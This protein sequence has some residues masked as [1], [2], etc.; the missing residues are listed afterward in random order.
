MKNTESKKKIET[1]V[2]GNL[3]EQANKGN[4]QAIREVAELAALHIKD[5]SIRGVRGDDELTDFVVQA[6]KKISETSTPNDAFGWSRRGAQPKN[7]A[8]LEWNLAQY[9]KEVLPQVDGNVELAIKIVG[10]AANMAGGKGGTME[11]IYY[12][13]KDIDL[14][15]DIF[16]SPPDTLQRIKR[17]ERRLSGIL[18]RDQ[19]K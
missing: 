13:W 10:E 1:F 4:H 8:E 3:M 6:L 15:E 11:T 12:R 9:I 2:D 16:P 18:K 19:Q 14:P 7:Q 17:I 5:L